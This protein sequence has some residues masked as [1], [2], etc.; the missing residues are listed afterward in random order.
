MCDHVLVE[1]A[2]A[3]SEA[4]REA[5]LVALAASETAR[6]AAEAALAAAEE[7]TRQ[8]ESQSDQQQG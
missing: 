8:L 1:E 5:A 4:A 7:R 3:V 6:E 2:L